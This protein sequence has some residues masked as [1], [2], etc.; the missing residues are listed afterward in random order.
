MDWSY[1]RKPRALVNQLLRAT[2]CQ[3]IS[4]MVAVFVSH[5]R[6]ILYYESS[7]WNEGK[8]RRRRYGAGRYGARHLG[9]RTIGRQ[10]FFF[11]R[12]VFL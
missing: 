2:I 8:F 11:I 12:F 10:D 4:F 6:P 1:E 3:D 7:L 5:I 9:A